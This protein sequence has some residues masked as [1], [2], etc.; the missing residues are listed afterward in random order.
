MEVTVVWR[1]NFSPHSIRMTSQ[2]IDSTLY[3][4]IGGVHENFQGTLMT[5][6]RCE[7]FLIKVG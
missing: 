4:V 5:V 6:V 7:S 1:T 2:Y 3:S